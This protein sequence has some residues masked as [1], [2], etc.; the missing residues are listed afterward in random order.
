[1]RCKLLDSPARR[2]R[3]VLVVVVVLLLL[4]YEN[5]AL[6]EN[7]TAVTDDGR[8]LVQSLLQLLI[9]YVS[10]YFD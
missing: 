9:I 5:K 3:H 1:L 7:I 2:L 6:Y 8:N 4:L 10:T